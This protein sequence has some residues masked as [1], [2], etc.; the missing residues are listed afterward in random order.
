[1]KRKK[2]FSLLD[3]LFSKRRVDIE[4]RQKSILLILFMVSFA[5]LNPLKSFIYDIVDVY[6]ANGALSIRRHHMRYK[7]QYTSQVR[8]LSYE[9]KE[10]KRIRSMYYVEHE[11]YL[12]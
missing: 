7:R 5:V 9:N 3:H 11:N 1:M 10:I 6:I 8:K 4:Y 2:I 12:K